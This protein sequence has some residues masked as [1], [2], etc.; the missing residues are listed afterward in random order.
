M[1]LLLAAPASFSSFDTK[2]LILG[3]RVKLVLQEL[4]A[5]LLAAPASL[6]ITYCMLLKF[7][8]Q[9]HLY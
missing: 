1:A 3:I 5:L 6:V 7:L 2:H 8:L 4:V 9:Q